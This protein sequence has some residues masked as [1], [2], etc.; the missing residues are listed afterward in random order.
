MDRYEIGSAG[1]MVGGPY[2]VKKVV[3][4]TGRGHL[5]RMG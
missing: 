4:V 3:T 1:G 5:E 2:R